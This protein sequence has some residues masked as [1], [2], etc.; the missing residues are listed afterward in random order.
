MEVK[1]K[2]AVECVRCGWMLAVSP[3]ANLS[4]QLENKDGALK[5]RG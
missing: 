5:G 3:G 4:Q 2:F 1:V